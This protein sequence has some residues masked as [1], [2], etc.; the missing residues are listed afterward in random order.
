[1]QY[2]EFLASKRI[3]QKPNGF[4]PEN[5]NPFLFDFQRDIV[6]WACRKGRAAESQTLTLF[7]MKQVC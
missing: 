6:T 4:E 2:D 7:D 3:T 1:M 5:L